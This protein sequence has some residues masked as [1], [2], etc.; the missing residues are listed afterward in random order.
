M[1]P[2]VYDT[3]QNNNYERLAIPRSYIDAS[4]FSSPEHLG[5][6]LKNLTLA[7]SSD[8]ASNY[9]AYFE[10]IN[11]YDVTYDDQTLHHTCEL[12]RKLHDN[13]QT[14]KIYEN[15]KKWLFEDAH[16]YQWSNK[17]NRSV[18]VALSETI[19]FTNRVMD[20]TLSI[21]SI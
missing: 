20:E 10:W 21:A 9:D 12:C 14:T 19:R 18:K 3:K 2:I 16:C 17:Y 11:Q 1:I 4:Q 5:E 7:G 8:V 6:Y 13:S 15:M